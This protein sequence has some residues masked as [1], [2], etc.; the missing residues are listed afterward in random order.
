MKKVAAIGFI[1][2]L[3]IIPYLNS[4]LTFYHLTPLDVIF[5]QFASLK[6]A[7]GNRLKNMF[8]RA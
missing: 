4:L 6:L 3:P 2:I 8:Y 1:S 7:N 5:F